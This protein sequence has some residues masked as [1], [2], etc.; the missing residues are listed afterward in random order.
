MITQN[1]VLQLQG[2]LKE[3][4][5]GLRSLRFIAAELN[6][7]AYTALMR[8]PPKVPQWVAGSRPYINAMRQLDSVTARYGLDSGYEIVLRCLCNLQS[9]RGEDARRIKAELQ[10]HLDSCPEGNR[11]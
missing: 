9:W 8:H 11:L 10:K 1:E 3:I 4:P 6:T 7:H 5:L 2:R